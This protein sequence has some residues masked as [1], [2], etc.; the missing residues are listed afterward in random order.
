MRFIRDTWRAKALDSSALLEVRAE[1]HLAR[2]AAKYAAEKGMEGFDELIDQ[3]IG[4]LE[5][6]WHLWSFYFFSFSLLVGLK[7]WL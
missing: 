4:I 5:G 1:P 6:A 7:L 2:M 3:S